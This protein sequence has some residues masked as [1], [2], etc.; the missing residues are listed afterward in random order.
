M[1]DVKLESFDRSASAD[2]FKLH[3][4]ECL[5]NS[6][7]TWN[8]SPGHCGIVWLVLMSLIRLK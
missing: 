6:T 5:S 4:L 7:L 3:I 8:D 2:E 1:V